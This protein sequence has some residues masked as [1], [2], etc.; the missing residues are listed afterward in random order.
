MGSRLSYFEVTSTDMERAQSF[1]RE[2][3]G[4]QVMALPEMGGYA[5]VDTQSGE[6][7]ASGGIGPVMDGGAGGIR[8]YFHEPDLTAGLTRAVE[9]GG[10]VVQEPT[11]IPGFGTIA[12]FADPDRHQV[13][14]WDRDGFGAA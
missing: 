8:V 6:G 14:L 11:E 2:M 5:V 12:V 1:Y 10:T 3:F 7:G 9:L 4:W 13:G